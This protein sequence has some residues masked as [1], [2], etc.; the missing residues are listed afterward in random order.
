MIIIKFAILALNLTPYF[1]QS[2]DIPNLSEQC[3]GWPDDGKTT[4]FAGAKRWQHVGNHRVEIFVS[5]SSLSNPNQAIRAIMPWARHDTSPQTKAVVVLSAE[6][7]LVVSD[8]SVISST[9]ESGDIVF[10]A[11][12]GPGLYHAYYFPY[13]NGGYGIDTQLAACDNNNNTSVSKKF[14][15]SRG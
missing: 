12:S 15:L 5:P 2:T 6:T 11:T 3:A 9:P 14:S 10:T 13:S 7:E 1:T 8:C 4:R